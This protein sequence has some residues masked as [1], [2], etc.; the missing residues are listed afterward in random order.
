MIVDHLKERV[1][2]L[3]I[4]LKNFSYVEKHF[5]SFRNTQGNSIYLG[6]LRQKHPVSTTES[7]QVFTYIKHSGKFSMF[8][9]SPQTTTLP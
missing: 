4:Y 6:H 7:K 9:S 2:Y 1:F 8:Y 5:N 3:P